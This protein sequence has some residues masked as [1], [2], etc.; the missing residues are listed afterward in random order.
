MAQTLPSIALQQNQ[1]DVPNPALTLPHDYNA[2]AALL[3]GALARGW[4]T[5]VAIR[6]PQETWSYARLAEYANRAGNALAR[7]GVEMEQ[8]V[9][10]VLYDSPQFAASF[11]G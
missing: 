2:A 10:L 5:R 6:A 7:L 4:G 3:D 9:A 11:F 8:R 1:S